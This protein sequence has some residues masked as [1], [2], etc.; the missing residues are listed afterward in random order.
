MTQTNKIFQAAYVVG[1]LDAA[2]DNWRRVVDVGPF[3]VSRGGAVDTLFH[4]GQP[5]EGFSADLALAQAG[6]VQIELI[7]PMSSGPN[8]FS[9]SVPAGTD[10]YHHQAYFTDD[11]DAE[12]ARFAA[13]DV[14]VAWNGSVGELHFAYFDT[15]HLVGCMTE[16]LEHEV[17]IEATFRMVADAA[18][19]WDGSDPVRLIGVPGRS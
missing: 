18:V 2:M 8:V 12:F 16:V 14:E 10:A 3:F 9:D 7:Q 6:P 1:D 5:I 17:N 15:R 19:A 4:R 11:L 13:M